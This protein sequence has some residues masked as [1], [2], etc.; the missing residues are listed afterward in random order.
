MHPVAGIDIKIAL[1]EEPRTRGGQGQG[2]V[3]YDVLSRPRGTVPLE[4]ADDLV[5]VRI[6]NTLEVILDRKNADHSCRVDG[7]KRIVEVVPQLGPSG[8]LYPARIPDHLCEDLLGLAV[9]ISI[10]AERDDHLVVR[11]NRCPNPHIDRPGP[12]L[13]S[14]HVID[15][16]VLGEAGN[17][18]TTGTRQLVVKE[19]PDGIVQIDVGGLEN[20][21]VKG[22]VRI[23]QDIARPCRVEAG[24]RR[25]RSVAFFHVDPERRVG[26]RIVIVLN[27]I[28]EDKIPAANNL[29]HVIAPPSTVGAVVT[30]A[31]QPLYDCLDRW[32][33][34]GRGWTTVSP[35]TPQKQ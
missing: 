17:V 24:S 15:D 21:G 7:H 3:I 23:D 1:L 27:D 4:V 12:E 13:L 28:S 31:R 22:T 35:T 10:Q 5:G 8:F 33:W 30:T 11:T 19:L 29:A 32:R 25:P 14:G 26:G 20:K 16:Y 18:S 34:R 2:R 9:R 6:P